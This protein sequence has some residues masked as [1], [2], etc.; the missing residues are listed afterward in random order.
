MGA[1][2]I[3]DR[4][5]EFTLPG[6]RFADGRYEHAEYSLAGRR[7]APVV[8]AFYPL[9]SSK[10][11]TE[12]LCSYQDDFEGFESLGADVWGISLQ[13]VESHEEFARKNGLTFPLLADHRDGV[14]S[15][16]GVALGGMLRR[17]VFIIDGD[18]IIRWKHVAMIGFTYR[19]A[20]E[21]RDQILRLFPAPAGDAFAFTPP[22]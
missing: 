14:G 12:Q 9:D 1:L 22:A 16:Y 13:G 2:E 17:A 8:L 11:C 15:A 6:I 3:G 18:G 19:R 20:S 21:I 5:P 4:A 7:G 10:V